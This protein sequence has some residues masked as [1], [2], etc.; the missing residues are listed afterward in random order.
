MQYALPINRLVVQPPALPSRKETFG[1]GGKG[2]EV[3][4]CGQRRYLVFF[5][6]AQEPRLKGIRGSRWSW[7][8]ASTD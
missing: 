5:A 4:F 1:W 8:G 3:R 2:G 6:R 7:L